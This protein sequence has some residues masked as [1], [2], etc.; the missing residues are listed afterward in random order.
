MYLPPL[1]GQIQP[2]LHSN[3]KRFKNQAWPHDVQWRR[4]DQDWVKGANRASGT[5]CRDHGTCSSNIEMVADFPRAHLFSIK[6][7][8][9]ITSNLLGQAMLK[10]VAPRSFHSSWRPHVL[11]GSVLLHEQQFLTA[12]CVQHSLSL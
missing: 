10:V 2:S 6:A 1:A 7:L 5:F 11:N 4:T 3:I 12:S 8:A 9:A